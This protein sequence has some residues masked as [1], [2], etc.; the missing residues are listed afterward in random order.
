[1]DRIAGRIIINQNWWGLVEPVADEDW[2]D[3]V[4]RELT[5]VE[6]EFR[7]RALLLESLGP[8]WLVVHNWREDSRK[9]MVSPQ[10]AAAPVQA[11]EAIVKS[12]QAEVRERADFW[13]AG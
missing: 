4:D 12:M 7:L 9:I 1:M 2:Y 5:Q 10:E 11:I 6:Y 8:E 13:K 3:E